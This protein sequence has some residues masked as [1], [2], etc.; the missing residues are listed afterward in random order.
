MIPQLNGL[1]L[2]NAQAMGQQQALAH[3]TARMLAN[4]MTDSSAAMQDIKCEKGARV[5]D[6]VAMPVVRYCSNGQAGD[7]KS[8][9]TAASTAQSHRLQLDKLVDAC[10]S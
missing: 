3:M 2:L 7:Q 9:L 6:F 1:P 10:L 8:S 5:A 4:E